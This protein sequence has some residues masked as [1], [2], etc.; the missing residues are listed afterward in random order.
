MKQARGKAVGS[1]KDEVTDANLT[2]SPSLNFNE[3][4]EF[5]HL[6]QAT[7]I[8]AHGKG[9]DAEAIRCVRD[10]FSLERAEIHRPFVISRLATTGIGWTATQ[11]IGHCS[12]ELKLVDAESRRQATLLIEELLDTSDIASASPATWQTERMRELA[13]FYD[14]T[15]GWHG[16]LFRPIL[17]RSAN[18]MATDFDAMIKAE[19]QETWPAARSLIPAGQRETANSSNW[20]KLSGTSIYPHGRLVLVRYSSIARRRLSATA[21]A[22]RLYQVDHQDQLPKLLNE[23]VPTYLP[24]VP[25]DAVSGLP[26]RYV[27][28]AN[29]PIVYAVGAR[30]RGRWRR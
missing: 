8:D 18:R 26:V 27:P 17:L 29:D 5:S 28:R 19:Q 11:T 13:Q 10:I 21:L 7:V 22:I 23:L 20:E 9:D 12:A 14:L 2:V 1:W 25:I 30:L 15:N 3:E 6:I 4:R 24:A 16:Y